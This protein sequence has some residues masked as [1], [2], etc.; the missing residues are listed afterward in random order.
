MQMSFF[1]F[2]LPQE[3][4]EN[5]PE[6]FILIF[7]MAAVFS[8][9]AFRKPQTMKINLFVLNERLDYFQIK[10]LNS[11]NFTHI[12]IPFIRRGSMNMN[13]FAYVNW[14]NCVDLPARCK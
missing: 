12:I 11:I 2:H 1:S 5:F 4:C 14:L 6:F 3:F 7:N 8:L 9:Q 10:Q 13:I